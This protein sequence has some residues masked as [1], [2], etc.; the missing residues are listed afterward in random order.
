MRKRKAALALSAGVM[1]LG[2]AAMPVPPPMPMHGPPAM[3]MPIDKR[4]RARLLRASPA[5]LEAMIQEEGARQTVYRDVAGY[6][7][8]G[9]GHLVRPEDG[10]KVGDR[11]SEDQVIDFLQQDIAIA[12]RAVARLVG[13]LPLLQ[14]E[15]DALVDLVFNVG[16]GNVSAE[17][18]P[19]LNA[20]IAAADYD[21]IAQE[22]GYHY[23]RGRIAKGLVYRSERRANIFMDASY[24]DPREGGGSSVT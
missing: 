20:A 11:I 13:D 16:E 7:T 24:E 21:G 8:V 14:H 9:V 18:S 17:R 15:F 4:K 23:A 5:L 10:L 6:P 22:L 19:R 1:G 12:E 3:T 2:T